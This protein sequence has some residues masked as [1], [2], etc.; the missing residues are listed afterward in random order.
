MVLSATINQY[1]YVSVRPRRDSRLTLAS[2]DYDT[3]AKYDHPRRMRFDGRLDLIKAVVKALRVRGG[4]DLW[5]HSDAPPGSGLGSSSTMVVALIGCISA[6]HGRALAGYDAAELAYRIERV[7]LGLAGGRQDQY[8]ATFGGIN[9]IEFHA[10]AT[11]VNPLRIRA[12][13]LNE[14]EYRLLLCYVGQTRQSAKII[15]RQTASYRERK[16]QVVAALH[17][18]KAETLEM[19]KAL[20]LGDVDGIGEL[21][22]QAWENKKKLDPGITTGRV[23]RLYALARKEGAIGG[24]MPGAGGGGYFLFLTRFDRKHR[25]AAALEKMGGQVV[26]F[27]FE[28]RGLTT[29]ASAP[30]RLAA[31]TRGAEAD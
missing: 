9:F 25:V 29:W 22:H 20:L 21:L 18:L 24:K 6:W 17:R 5:T 16:P 3:V 28:K 23:D 26:P 12:D 4:A 8:A 14:L 7:D 2:L 30:G 31:R 1:A 19:K 15:E 13:V 27:Q 10:D 11:V